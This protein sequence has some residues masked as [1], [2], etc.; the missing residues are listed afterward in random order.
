MPD[1]TGR[2]NFRSLPP[3]MPGGGEGIR[4]I[5]AA[6][7]CLLRC[8]SFACTNTFTL[9]FII[10]PGVRQVTRSSATCVRQAKL[11]AQ[12]SAA[13]SMPCELNTV[14]LLR[15]SMRAIPG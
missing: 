13:N 12:A 11:L 2:T 9:A 6:E 4:D 3:P 8:N 5:F 10:A 15:Y 14:L 1:E 7:R